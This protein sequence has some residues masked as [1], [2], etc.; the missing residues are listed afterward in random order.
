MISAKAAALAAG[1]SFLL[2]GLAGCGAGSGQERSQGAGHAASPPT[3]RAE[4][5]AAVASARD[6]RPVI[7]FVG[8]SL[9]AG[10]GLDPEDAYPALLQR[11]IDVAGLDYRVVNAGVSGETSA[12]ARR[13]IGWL[14]R[15]RVAVLALETGANDGL[16]GQDPEATEA[17]IQAIF[18]EARRQVPPPKLV[19]MAMEALP[20]YGESYRRRFRALFPEVARRNG[21]TLVP[22]LLAGV[23]ADPGLNQ[24]DGIHPNA[25]GERRVADNVWKALLP[26]LQGPR[27]REPARTRGVEGASD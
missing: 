12:G 13:R 20:N 27:H 14:M 25:E 23:A 10:Y 3:E 2:G 19:L 11:K 24:A 7:L 17:N 5:P 6:A 8:T 1:L 18:D 15:Q 9:T 16:R 22:F 4:T 21:A 26:I